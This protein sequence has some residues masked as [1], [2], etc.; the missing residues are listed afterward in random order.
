MC[1]KMTLACLKFWFRYTMLRLGLDERERRVDGGSEGVA[2]AVVVEAMDSAE[3]ESFG[4]AGDGMELS[5]VLM[6][7]WWWS[8]DARGRFSRS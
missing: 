5:H 7:L 3:E 6:A 2:S 1:V 4:D 8:G